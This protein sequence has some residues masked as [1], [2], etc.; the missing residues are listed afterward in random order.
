M[1]LGIDI[2]S[3]G[4]RALVIDA[5]GRIHA[6]SQAPLP[7]ANGEQDPAL[8]LIALQSALHSI[9]H[10]LPDLQAMAIDG[11]SAT[12][13]LSD[14]DGQALGPALLYNDQRAQAEAVMLAAQFPGQGSNLSALAKLLWLSRHQPTS[15]HRLRYIQQQA[16]WLCATLS[17]QWGRCD[18]ANALKLG[19]D[20][21]K[22]AWLP[23]LEALLSA[24]HI[25]PSCLP[26]IQASGSVIGPIRSDWADKLGLPRRLLMVSG[27]TDSM[28]ALIAA[29]VQ[30]P[31]QA[32]SSL[33]ST[34]AI[35][36]ASHAR[37]EIP[38]LGIYSHRL[39]ELWLPGGSANAGGAVLRQHFSDAAMATMTT[40]LCT[41]QPSG[42]Y[43]YPLPSP[44]ER[45]LICD[46]TF[47]GHVSANASN[48]L[49]QFQGMLEGL[50]YIEAWGYRLLQDH[51]IAINDGVRTLGG[52]AKN[53]A[54]TQI[55]ANILNQPL[56]TP[57]CAE[58]AL[59]AAMLAAAPSLGGLQHAQD[60][61]LQP[62]QHTLPD[63]RN[64]L[65]Y[66][67]ALQAFME[68]YAGA[69]RMSV[70]SLAEITTIHS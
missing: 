13:V 61:L 35:K 28:A 10:A 16:D 30:R 69:V 43:D 3:S 26:Q 51:G 4:L 38:A 60:Q 24:H 23:G 48:P 62:C 18:P 31:G 20:A 5:D 54:W 1:F 9:R 45:F 39:G 36:L 15:M 56:H 19:W 59:G 47:A 49:Q 55:R 53:H 21:E 65:H 29:G 34:L 57:A 41:T 7:A 33:G 8:W 32:V 44:G 25:D 12:L 66:R 50:A 11:T 58:A 46:R 42:V 2:G 37:L 17:G 14:Q 68:K 22:S 63:T 27:S 67:D 70:S 52:G 64:T 40:Q 6:Q